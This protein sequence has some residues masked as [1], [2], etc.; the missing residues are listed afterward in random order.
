MDKYTFRFGGDPTVAGETV[1]S[2]QGN[3]TV[4]TAMQS[5]EYNKALQDGLEDK[6]LVGPQPCTGFVMPNFE[7]IPELE[8]RQA[9]AY[10]YD[11]ENIWSAANEVVGVTLA[12]GV[13]DESLGF[14]LLP[15]GMAGREVV[16]RPR[17][18][19]HLVRP[20]A[21]EGAAGRGGLRAGR[22]RGLVRL[23]RDDAR[24]RGGCGAAA[25]WLRGG[26]LLGREVPL[27]GGQPVRRVDRPGQ[28]AVQEDQPS[29]Y[30]VVPGLAVGG[31]LHA[32]HRRFGPGARALQHRQ[33]QRRRC[34]RRDRG[35][36]GPCRSTSRP[37][38]GVRW[39]SG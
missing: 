6:I 11:Y 32:G 33:V 9:L 29:R 28:Q 39:S 23:R 15:P 1:L 22:V 20:R 10:A 34:G 30:R 16:E 17:R 19:G 12:N 31:D 3:T 35:D 8:V 27:H 13:T 36:Q 4:V 24:G 37:R 26:R 25:A 5:T 21:V 7:K 18:R 2:D 14:G 38:P